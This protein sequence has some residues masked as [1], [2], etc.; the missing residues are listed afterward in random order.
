MPDPFYGEKGCIF[1]IPRAGFQ[2]PDVKELAALLTSLGLAKYKCP[3][4]IEITD[5]F[6]VTGV[7]KLD[8][9][10][11]KKAIAEKLLSEQHLHHADHPLV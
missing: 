2:V 5:T 9:P 10:A 11:L 4:R 8:K 6:P 3:E 7:R 1:I